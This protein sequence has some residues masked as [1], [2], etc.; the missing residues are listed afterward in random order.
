MTL[1]DKLFLG[2]KMIKH[3]EVYMFHKYGVMNFRYAHVP[4][5]INGTLE[6][7]FSPTAQLSCTLSSC[8]I[9]Q[10]NTKRAH[11]LR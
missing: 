6:M 11:G 7:N 2:S 10:T 8:P 4:H 3:L 5:L 9:W 1:R